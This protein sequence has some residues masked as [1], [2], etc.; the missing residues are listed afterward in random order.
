[1]FSD[2]NKYK[3]KGLWFASMSQVTDGMPAAPRG[4]DAAPLGRP[5]G[6]PTDAGLTSLTSVC[7]SS[8]PEKV[9]HESDLQNEVQLQKLDDQILQLLSEVS[10]FPV[11]LSS[12][13]VEERD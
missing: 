7:P 13:F 6:A 11:F 5:P 8:E 10:I 2:F 4:G 12:V 3:G 9:H 1:M